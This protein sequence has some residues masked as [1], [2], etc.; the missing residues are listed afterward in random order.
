MSPLVVLFLIVLVDL[1]GFSL[2][3]PLLPPF[4]AQYGFSKG[5]IGLL[6]A[7]FPIC[8]LIAGPILGRLS[9]RYGRRP[10]LAVS[11]AGT[12]ISFLIL[13]LSHDFRIMLLARMLDGASG[14][15]ILVAQAYIADVTEGKDRA[16]GMGIIGAAFGIGF[17]LGPILGGLLL[18]LP[19]DP[20]WRLRLPFLLAAGLSTVAWLLVLLRLPE[21]TTPGER[22]AARVLTVRGLV[23]L[24]RNPLI[25]R[26]VVVSALVT[27][28]F[29]ALEGTFSLYLEERMG[30]SAARAAYLF[31]Y[32]GVISAIVQGG[33]L[34]RLVPRLGEARLILAGSSLLAA[35]LAGL[36]L[37][38]ALPALLAAAGAVAA[39]YSLA[40]PSLTGLVSRCSP[41][42][43]Q[44]AILG[45]MLS[46]QTLARIL[47]YLAANHLL[48][49]HGPAAPYWEAAALAA[50]AFV[51]A[52][53][54]LG[55]RQRQAVASTTG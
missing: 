7:A 35:G 41:G 15:N 38:H 32:V 8:Q 53:F 40:G 1:L 22:D 44:G 47:N 21:S 55:R 23:D 39:G 31:A 42:D 29:S 10:V 33:L 30:Y 34:R 17:V 11:Q 2:V 5:Q 45:V 46:A 4:A 3:M 9:D 25:A 52:A 20:V 12:S 54:T 19:I 16:R 13:A 28:A 37:A 50:A 14:G 6:L 49:A 18:S 51:L 26:L 27:L 48:G 24:V 43:E 36:A